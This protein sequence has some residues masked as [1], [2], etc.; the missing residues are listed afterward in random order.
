MAADPDPQASRSVPWPR[1][2]ITCQEPIWDPLMQE[3]RFSVPGTLFF[4]VAAPVGRLFQAYRRTL[5][6]CVLSG[7]NISS[8]SPC[9]RD[10]GPPVVPR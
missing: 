9:Y 6:T 5:P 10:L 8:M 3:S 2:Q 1:R 7:L 4:L